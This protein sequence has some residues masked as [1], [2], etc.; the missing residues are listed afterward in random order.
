MYPV[1][2][3][4]LASSLHARYRFLAPNGH[5]HGVL[6][7][8]SY[9]T[10][11]DAQPVCP[12]SATPARVIE[13][14]DGDTIVVRLGGKPFHVRYIGIDAPEMHSPATG[15]AEP[16]A[17]AAKKANERLTAGRT[18]FLEP[19][20]SDTDR[21]GRLLRYVWLDEKTMISAELARLGY[22]RVNRYPPD[23]R[24]QAFLE[25]M[26]REARKAR[27]GIWSSAD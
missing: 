4:R 22:A 11:P 14:I 10:A 1:P 7:Q 3:T 2:S 21:H 24:H 6:N 23:T 18:V 25:T 19:D 15:S 27:R 16:F 5:R 20:I 8:T 17:H 12:S 26:E 9:V 13:I